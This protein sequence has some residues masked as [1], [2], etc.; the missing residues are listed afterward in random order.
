MTLQE[1]SHAISDSFVRILRP[2]HVRGKGR[3][4]ERIVP[5]TG[6]RFAEIFD[7]RIKLDLSDHIQRWIYFG[8]ME[9]Q[10]TKWVSKWLRPGMT[11]ID[12]GANVGYYTLLG[13]SCVGPTGK[14]FAVEPSPYAYSRLTQTVAENALSQ[15][16]TLPIALGSTPGKATL[17]TPPPHNHTPSMV[18]AGQNPGIQVPVRTLEDCVTEWSIKQADLLKLDVEGFEPQVLAGALSLMNSGKIRAIL[19]EFND[20][21]LRKAGTSAEEFHGFV[22][23]QGFADVSEQAGLPLDSFSSR[24]FVHRTAKAS[25][26]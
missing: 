6:E 1:N 10:E 9:P 15:V 3:L 24:V 21:W 20:W 13:A 11:M 16:V 14:V 12:V 5:K 8:V 22:C 17:Y 25:I 4:L 2:I 18:P 26:A 7:S 19:C 23:S